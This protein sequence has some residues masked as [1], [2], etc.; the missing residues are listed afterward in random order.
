MNWKIYMNKTD[1][2]FSI[3]IPT[4]NRAQFIP[5][6][7]ASVLQQTFPSFEVIVVD[8][9][10][11]DNTRQLVEGLGSDKVLYF[12]KQNGERGAARNFGIQKASGQYISF[13]DSDDQLYPDHLQ[14]AYN[15]LSREPGITCYAQAYEIREATN[16]RI[17][18]PGTFIGTETIN[19]KLIAGNFL[20][21]FGV[22]VRKEV[23]T[24]LRFEEDRR[25]A[26]T[27]DWLLWLQ[28]AARYPFYY[29]N[30]VTGA[31]LEHESR[32]VLSFREESLLFRTM[33]LKQKLESDPEFVAA[34]GKTAIQR[35]YAHMLTYTSLHLA[36][37]RKKRKALHYWWKAL[38]AD[39]AEVLSRR[40]LAIGKKLLFN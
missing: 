31:M 30:R 32:S 15:R 36:M 34:F 20:S 37:S 16:G 2:F 5:A 18:V 12:K 40:S 26:G 39:S 7:L 19:E 4:Y 29:S 17:L 28:L 3:I 21:C 35:V 38:K 8:D 25:F 24:H 14:E 9:G 1:L 23:L 13:L 33:A 22:F 27:E 10:G 6:T 11:T